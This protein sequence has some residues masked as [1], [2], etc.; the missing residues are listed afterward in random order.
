MTPE[1]PDTPTEEQAE[2]WVE[3]AELSLAPGFRSS[4][5]RLAEDHVADLPHRRAR[6][7][8]GVAPPSPVGRQG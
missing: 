1:L 2:A 5:R 4:V 3:L 8:P 6:S 7:V